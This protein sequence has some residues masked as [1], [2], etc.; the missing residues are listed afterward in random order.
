MLTALLGGAD[1]VRGVV[2]SE[3][4]EEA[5]G[6]ESWPSASAMSRERPWKALGA[7]IA[8]DCALRRV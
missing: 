2:T 3:R 5:R 4:A 6:L 7:A 8:G 1:H